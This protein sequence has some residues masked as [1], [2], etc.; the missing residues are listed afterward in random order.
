MALQLA[1]WLVSILCLIPLALYLVGF[2]KDPFHPLIFVGALTFFVACYQPLTDLQPALRYVNVGEIFYY[3]MVV[4]G[5]TAALYWGYWYHRRRHRYDE[6]SAAPLPPVFNPSRL[7]GYGAA[8]TIIGVSCYLYTR[9]DY[10]FTGYIRAWGLVWVSGVILVTQS[11]LLK[12]SNLHLGL[13][14]IAIA[15]IPPIDRFFLYGQRG[16][17]FRLA[18]IFIPAF[19]FFAKRPIRAF[20]IPSAIGLVLVLSVL[21]TTRGYVE[22]GLASNRITALIQV[23][24]NFFTRQPTSYSGTEDF[25]FGSAMIDVVRTNGNYNYG[26]SFTDFVVR[27][28]PKELVEKNQ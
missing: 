16:D 27:F 10:E 12:R 28:L 1:L 9:T 23:L 5:S 4:G 13:F 18:I 26:R 20:F 22:K 17:T 24:P 14:F 6:P 25:I 21:Q 8:L 11:I 2:L 15:L 7:M 3:I 19:L